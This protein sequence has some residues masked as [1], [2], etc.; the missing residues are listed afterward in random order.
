M[1]DTN[2][3]HF[4]RQHLKGNSNWKVESAATAL[5]TLKD[6]SSLRNLI[7]LLSHKNC[8]VRKSSIKAL[9]EIG[10]TEAVEYLVEHAEGNIIHVIRSLSKIGG[11]KSTEFII[12]V[13]NN[14]NSRWDEKIAAISALESIGNVDVVVHIA[15]ALKNDKSVSRKAYEALRRLHW[16][17]RHFKDKLRASVHKWDSSDY[18]EIVKEAIEKGDESL[19]DDLCWLITIRG[20]SIIAEWYCNAGHPKLYDAGLSWLAPNNFNIVESKSET[21]TGPEW[22]QKK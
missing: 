14:K 12:D 16:K 19:V 3:T 13:L 22:G 2:A 5:G 10:S 18:R 7:G 17:P 9:G 4:F 21:Y 11:D 1:K 20:D 15:E 6:K 8:S